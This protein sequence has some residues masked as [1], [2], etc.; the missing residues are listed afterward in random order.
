MKIAASPLRR[1][2][3]LVALGAAAAAFTWSALVPGTDSPAIVLIHVGYA[4]LAAALLVAALAAVRGHRDKLEAEIDRSKARQLRLE[5]LLAAISTAVLVVDRNGWILRANRGAE[6]LT[7]RSTSLLRGMLVDAVVHLGWDPEGGANESGRSEIPV[8]GGEPIPVGYQVAAI[9]PG[10]DRLVMLHDLRPHYA[11]LADI[12][13]EAERLEES[14][15]SRS[16]FV[17][18]VSH[19]LRTPMDALVGE[20]ARLLELP[21]LDVRQRRYVSIINRNARLMLELLDDMLLL[22]TLDARLGTPDLEEITVLRLLHEARLPRPQD[23]DSIT[24]G[25][26]IPT[27]RVDADWLERVFEEVLD[28]MPFVG[29]PPLRYEH[30]LE[31]REYRLEIPSRRLEP[32]VDEEFVFSP[33]FVEH[34]GVSPLSNARLGLALAREFV[35]GMGGDLTTRFAGEQGHFVLTLPLAGRRET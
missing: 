30:R 9:D 19:Q 5:A 4:G 2:A 15:L 10:D 28:P 7:G 16:R 3:A 21:P 14:G 17:A 18:Q 33:H 27:V 29:A 11:A 1:P 6:E 22:T 20:A 13:S 32:G 25:R 35:R 24:S 8:R 23:L 34:E 12:E 26:N 31:P